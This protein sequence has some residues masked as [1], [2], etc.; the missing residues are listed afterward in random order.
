MEDRKRGREER[1]EERKRGREEERKRGR[2][3][4]RKREERKREKTMCCRMRAPSIPCST[5]YAL[6]DIRFDESRD[7][8]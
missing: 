8:C 1:E 2:E 3:E 6:R 7:H 5:Q 4:E